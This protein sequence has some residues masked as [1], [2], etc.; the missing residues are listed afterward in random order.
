MKKAIPVLIA[1]V[2]I[3]IIG[4]VAFVPKIIEKYSYSYEQADLYEY[5]HILYEEEVPIILQNE[6]I[7]AKAIMSNGICYL[8][9]ATVHTYFNDRFYVDYVEQLLLYTTPTE[10]IRTAIGSSEYLINQETKDA[11]YQ[12]SFSRTNLSLSCSCSAC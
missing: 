6:M 8:D 12:I 7:D 2:L 1:I 9:L 5:F 4:G 10:I 11:G 3:L